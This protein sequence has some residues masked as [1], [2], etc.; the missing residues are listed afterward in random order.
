M[1]A[2]DSANLPQWIQIVLPFPFGMTQYNLQS[3]NLNSYYAAQAA[4]AWTIQ[5]F[6]GA[7]WVSLDSK[8]GVL[9]MQNTIQYFLNSPK[10][11]E[12]YSI[13]RLYVTDNNGWTSS[14][15]FKCALINTFNIC[16]NSGLTGNPTSEPTQRPI[17]KPTAIPSVSPIVI[18]TSFAPLSALPSII[19]R[20]YDNDF[21]TTRN[22]NKNFWT[23]TS[24]FS[25]GSTV[26]VEMAVDCPKLGITSTLSSKLKILTV[27]G[28]KDWSAGTSSIYQ[29]VCTITTPILLIFS[30]KFLL[31]IIMEWFFYFFILN[32][33]RLL[34][35]VVYWSQYIQ[36]ILMNLSYTL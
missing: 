1:S 6:N 18:P 10:N 11:T 3:F 26:A 36:S 7:T 20:N 14:N 22:E 4:S 13:F 5:A 24:V 21:N 27:S 25:A 23:L 28:E 9:P 34:F 2:Y 8:T 29:R 31:I 32:C 12:Y 33:R 35:L 16:G 17:P 30:F 15:G 19:P